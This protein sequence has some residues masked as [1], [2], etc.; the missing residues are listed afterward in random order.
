MDGI[1]TKS[2]EET[3]PIESK[4][5]Q[6]FVPDTPMI[7]IRA[8]SEF[9]TEP[10]YKPNRSERRRREKIQGRMIRSFL[11]RKAKRDKRE[12]GKVTNG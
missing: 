11:K 4:E 9:P 3:T 5:N 10:T 8:V 7:P 1:T 2:M 6:T 12:A